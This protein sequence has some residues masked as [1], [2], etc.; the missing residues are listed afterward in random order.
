MKKNGFTLIE[1]L[2]VIVIMAILLTIAVPNVIGISKKIRKNMYCSKVEDIEAAAKLYGNDYIDE[3]EKHGN[4][5][6]IN[7]YTL[8]EN[9]LFKKE[10][11]N[12]VLRSSDNY[13]IKDP[14]DN[15]SMDNDEIILTKRDKRITAE[16]D[17][18]KKS[19]CNE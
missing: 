10:T 16:Y 13:C 7:V 9:N 18:N 5:M 12:C 8:V 17:K 1:L 4:T 15:S 14:R 3:I 2:A 19:V 6:K 11:D